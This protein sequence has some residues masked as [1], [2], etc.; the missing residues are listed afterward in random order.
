MCNTRLSPCLGQAGLEEGNQKAQVPFRE[1]SLCTLSA[2]SPLNPEAQCFSC[3]AS[4]SSRCQLFCRIDTT[5]NHCRVMLL[6]IWE[7]KELKNES[8]RYEKLLPL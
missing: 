3:L 7:C 6:R 4:T 5:G 8:G 1:A 2:R